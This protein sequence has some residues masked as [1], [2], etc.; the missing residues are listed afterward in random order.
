M[1]RALYYP[2]FQYI[3]INYNFRINYISLTKEDSI[4]SSTFTHIANHPNTIIIVNV[5]AYLPL[6]YLPTKDHKAKLIE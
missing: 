4:I 2:R 6:W 1:V 3:I 5:N